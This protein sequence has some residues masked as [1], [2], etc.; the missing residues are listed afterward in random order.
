[1]EYSKILEILT[2]TVPV[3][4][5]AGIGKLLGHFNIISTSNRQPLSWITYYLALPAL[6]FVSFLEK[7]PFPIPLAS[8]LTLSLLPIFITSFFVFLFLFPRRSFLDNEKM[9]ATYYLSYWGNNGYMGIPLAVSAVGVTQGLPL[10]A[11]INGL[12]VPFYI[13]FSMILMYKTKE[14]GAE[15]EQLKGEFLHHTLLNPVILAMI[16]GAI[17]SSLKPH[18]AQSFIHNPV[19]ISMFHIIIRLFGQIGDM[20][21]PLALILVGSNLKVKEIHSDKFLLALVVIGKL[22]IAPAAVYFFAYLLFPN[23]SK[24][25]FQVLILMNAVPGAVASYIISAKFKCAEEFVSSSLVLT[26]L[27]SIITIPLWLHAIL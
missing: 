13:T 23:L 26:T 17:L 22:I 4:A 20:G 21:L 2:I 16:L 24:A 18:L 5:L 19:V 6:I 1:M 3:F 10:A 9:S 8:L 27:F 12:S 25:S 11:V 7:E 15:R 14:H